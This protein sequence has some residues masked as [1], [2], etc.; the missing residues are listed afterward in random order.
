MRN[1]VLQ[2][3]ADENSRVSKADL[4]LPCKGARLAEIDVGSC[5][6]GIDNVRS[7]CHADNITSAGYSMRNEVPGSMR[8]ARRAGTQEA[9]AATSASTTTASVKMRGSPGEVW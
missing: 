4:R 1:E 7:P 8:A 9:T 5:A 3:Y 6:V 2:T